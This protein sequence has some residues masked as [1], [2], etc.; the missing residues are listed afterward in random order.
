M[1]EENITSKE[2]KFNDL[3]RK[4]YRFVCFIECLIIKWILESYDR[5]I[6]QSRDKEKYIHKGLF[7]GW[8][9]AYI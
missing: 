9:F 5:K 8:K 7:D 1:L 6:M 4:I 3:E 2:L